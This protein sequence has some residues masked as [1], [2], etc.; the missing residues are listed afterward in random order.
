ME[1]NVFDVLLKNIDEL[2]ITEKIRFITK[3]PFFSLMNQ[4][5]LFSLMY[6]CTKKQYIKN[7]ILYKEND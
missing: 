1:K 5:K 3:F 2:D 7:D 4:S 6:E